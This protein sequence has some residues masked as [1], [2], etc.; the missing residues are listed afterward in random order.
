MGTESSG[1]EMAGATSQEPVE[2]VQ[3]I[4]MTDGSGSSKRGL[5]ASDDDFITPNKTAKSR[6]FSQDSVPT[7]N[8][9]NLIMGVNDIMSDDTLELSK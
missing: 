8:T 2:G 5:E 9:F 1:T 6:S 3:E 4:E 7:S